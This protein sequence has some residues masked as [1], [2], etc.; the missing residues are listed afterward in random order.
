M[1]NLTRKILGIPF[2]NPII[3]PS[4]PGGFGQ[5]I[6]RSLLSKIGAFTIKSITLEPKEGNPPPRLVDA[7]YGLINSI[8]LQNPGIKMFLSTIYPKLCPFPTKLFFS[9]AGNSPREFREMAA[10][11]NGIEGFELLELNLSCPNVKDASTLLGADPE[12]VAEILKQVKEVFTTRPVSVKLPPEMPDLPSVIKACENNGADALTLFN[13]ITGARFDITT[14]KPFL[15]RVYGG[16]SGPAVKPIYLR[17]IYLARQLTKL[18]IIGMGGAYEWED[19]FEYLLA[20][21]DLVGFGLRTMVDLTEVAELPEKAQK[22][23]FNHGYNTLSE[24]LQSVR[25]EEIK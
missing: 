20:G 11:L 3:I 5:E 14:G 21:A 13:C 12:P 25:R 8:G 23:L 6:N 10:V 24:Y 22:W 15:K 1:A 2:K 4:G 7:G 17:K 19:I 9:I 18:P 16:Y